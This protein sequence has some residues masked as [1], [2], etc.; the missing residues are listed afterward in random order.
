MEILETSLEL[1]KWGMLSGIFLGISVS[2]TGPLL[3]LKKNALFPHSLTHVLFLVIILVSVITQFLPEFFY[4][5]L[6]ILLTLLSVSGIWIFKKFQ[7]LYEDTATSIITHLALALALIVAATNSQYDLRL[8]SYLFGS[9]LTVTSKEVYESLIILILSVLLYLKFKGI[10]VAQT[11]DSEVPGVN[12]KFA[13]LSFLF[14]ITLQT[15]IGIR[16][17]GILL[18]SSFFVFTSVVALKISRS[19]GRVIILTAFLN[20]LAL[21]GGFLISFIWDWPFSASTV[22]FMSLYFLILLIIKK[23]F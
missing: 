10:W 4:Y 23:G 22:F 5:P 2:F 15:L 7:A 16:I 8:F 1:V 9:L 19:F 18:V 13:N 21:I 11:V 3:V 14:L 20:L 17:L 12:F 6:I